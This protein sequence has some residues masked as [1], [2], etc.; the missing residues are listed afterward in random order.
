MNFSVALSSV[1]H[2]EA[3]KH[4]LR[5]DGQE[6]LCFALW[7]PSYGKERTTA[8]IKSIIMPEPDEHSVHGNVAFKSHFFE[9]ALSIAL[10]HKAGL[11]FMHSHLGRGWQA[12]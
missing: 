3:M 5:S 2:N 10:T 6:D 7:Y 11:A 4:L 1:T 12:M 9:R 8:L